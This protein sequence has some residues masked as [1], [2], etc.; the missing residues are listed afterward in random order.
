LTQ[1]KDVL[2]SF[3]MLVLMCYRICC[4][5]TEPEGIHQEKVH[6]LFSAVAAILRLCG[7][8]ISAGLTLLPSLA[9]HYCQQRWDA[10]VSEGAG[11]Y[12]SLPTFHYSSFI[13]RLGAV[14]PPPSTRFW[15]ERNP[16]PPHVPAIFSLKRDDVQVSVRRRMASRGCI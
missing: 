12:S 3:V 9:S 8:P 15:I 2:V 11:E 5:D 13:P 10:Q 7:A 16:F 6:S 4:S 1:L 14:T